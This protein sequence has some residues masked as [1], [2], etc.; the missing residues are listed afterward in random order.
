MYHILYKYMAA[1][2]NM[3]TLERNGSDWD[4]HG[5]RHAPLVAALR[6]YAITNGA[7]WGTALGG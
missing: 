2:L 5:K 6:P 3:F 7:Q 1:M 4:A